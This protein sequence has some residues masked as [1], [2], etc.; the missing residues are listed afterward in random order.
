MGRVHYHHTVGPLSDA[1]PVADIADG[2]QSSSLLSQDRTLA[3]WLNSL[4]NCYQ[5]IGTDL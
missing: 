2:T 5:I 3:S 4:G 1:F